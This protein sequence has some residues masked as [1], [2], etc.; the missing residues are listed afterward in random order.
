MKS[1]EPSGRSQAL[2][3]GGPGH[4]AGSQETRALVPALPGRVMRLQSSDSLGAG[5]R[6][7]LWKTPRQGEMFPKVVS[8]P[9][10]W[11]LLRKR[12]EGRTEACRSR[13]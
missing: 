6:V 2:P 3:P 10:V 9:I 12:T 13:L 1:I 7:L 11:I 5:L 8:L 4:E